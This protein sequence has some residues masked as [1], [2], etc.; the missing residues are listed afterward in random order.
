KPNPQ[1]VVPQLFEDHFGWFAGVAFG[2]I[3]IGAL[4]PAAIMSI[5]A[6]NLFTRNIWREFIE[7][8][9]SPR[10]EAAV[11]RIASLVVKA[12]ALAFALSLDKQNAIN[13]QLLGG[14][15]I[16]QTLP[17]IV[18]G[19]YTRWFHRWALLAGWAVGIL[20]GTVAAY[21]QS[22]AAT[23][24]FGASTSAFFGYGNKVYIGLTALLLNLVVAVLLTL[25]FRAM[26]L[27]EGVDATTPDDY[28][29]DEGD[30]RLRPVPELTG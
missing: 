11:S 22:S 24:H 9:A 20:Y 1:L 27:P 28:Y 7:P 21:G 15:W 14:I 6:A 2:A 17:S 25:L 5:G 4:V 26:R 23:K 30:P 13:F 3:A 8:G 29:A 18:I 10:R 12:G 16:L 19:L